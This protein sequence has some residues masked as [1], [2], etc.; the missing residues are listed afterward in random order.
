MHQA[1]SEA[2]FQKHARRYLRR[3]DADTRSEKK[4]DAQNGGYKRR[5]AQEETNQEYTIQAKVQA[6]D[7]KK[8]R[9]AAAHN[10]ATVEERKRSKIIQAV[11]DGAFGWAFWMDHRYTVSCLTADASEADRAYFSADAV[12]N[13]GVLYRVRQYAAFD[14]SYPLMETAIDR[15]QLLRGWQKFAQ[16]ASAHSFDEHTIDGPCG[17]ETSSRHFA[18]AARKPTVLHFRMGKGKRGSENSF[19]SPAPAPIIRSAS[20]AAPAAGSSISASSSSSCKP[21]SPTKLQREQQHN[22]YLNHLRQKLRELIVATQ[23]DFRTCKEFIGKA[24]HIDKPFR[25]W[26]VKELKQAAKYAE[27]HIDTIQ[28]SLPPIAPAAS[29]SSAAAAPMRFAPVPVNDSVVSL[30]T[31]LESSLVSS[32]SASMNLIGHDPLESLSRTFRMLDQDRDEFVDR[33]EMQVLLRVAGLPIH[34]IRGIS[35]DGQVCRRNMRQHHRQANHNSNHMRLLFTCVFSL[36][37]LDCR[38]THRSSVL[39]S[40]KH[41]FGKLLSSGRSPDS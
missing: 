22:R 5:R 36:R 11:F 30:E 13:R 39:R 1:Q 20:D 32:S 19:P 27:D 26:N 16:G 33:Q 40:V 15:Q 31:P 28:R 10:S 14:R 4:R 8:A 23:R 6:Q 2:K 41:I 35:Q 7:D 17:S 24:V 29:S 37:L 9:T 3:L 34:R 18:M 12:M 21:S 25:N 38:A